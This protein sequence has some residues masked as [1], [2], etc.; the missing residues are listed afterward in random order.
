VKRI[1]AYRRSELERALWCA[2][3][4][5]VESSA[6]GFFVTPGWR[7]VGPPACSPVKERD[8]DGDCTVCRM[9]HIAGFL[10]R[11]AVAEIIE[12]FLNKTAKPPRAK[13]RG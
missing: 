10:T 11:M 6:A 7:E 5:K 4:F 2:G 9:P 8:A 1:A 3:P 13:R 12:K